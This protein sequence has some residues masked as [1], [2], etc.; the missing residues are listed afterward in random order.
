M[1]DS[2]IQMGGIAS[3]VS[4]SVISCDATLADDEL[5]I[6]VAELGLG[7]FMA[8][9]IFF[10]LCARNWSLGILLFNIIV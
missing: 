1:G 6:A 4:F 3:N 10:H 8:V 2:D 9:N 5:T 7:I